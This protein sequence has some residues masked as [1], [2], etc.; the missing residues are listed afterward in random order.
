MGT[1]HYQATLH[2]AFA[3]PAGT[4][5]AAIGQSNTL[6]NPGR[7]NCLVCLDE[8]RAPARYNVDC[9]FG[10]L[11]GVVAHLLVILGLNYLRGMQF[12]LQT[13]PH[14]AHYP[15]DFDVNAF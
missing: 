10:C 8:K 1:V 6:T 12:C 2:L 5:F 4:V 7:Q 9:E 13:K 14:L 15:L 11:A 3:R